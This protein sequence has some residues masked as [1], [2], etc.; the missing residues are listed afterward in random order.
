MTPRSHL[1]SDAQ[2]AVVYMA[3][4]SM[5]APSDADVALAGALSEFAHVVWVD[6]PTREGAVLERVTA[7]LSRLRC[8]R[9]PS[10]WPR[11]MRRR[12]FDKSI[13][14]ALTAVGARDVL[15]VLA[16]P[17]GRFPDSIDGH[18]LF[19]VTDDWVS[20]A[21]RLGL[22]RRAVH[23]AIEE[24]CARADSIASTSE[25]LAQRLH[26]YSKVVDA[27]R[28]VAPGCT[29]SPGS[30]D[31]PKE[32]DKS[33]VV[34]AGPLDDTWD[35]STLTAVA[36]AGYEIEVM[37][38]PDA[39]RDP[40]QRAA[41]DA[42]LAHPR[43]HH[44]AAG[45]TSASVG[46]SVGIAP[47]VDDAFTRARYPR[48]PLDYLAAGLAVVTTDSAFTR[49]SASVH[50][51]TAGSTAEFVARVSDA[52]AVPPDPATRRA[53]RVIAA[54]HSWTVRAVTMLRLASLYREAEMSEG[55]P[56]YLDATVH[57]QQIP[58]HSNP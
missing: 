20:G 34:V 37:T 9:T 22:N 40:R 44:D 21:P 5:D 25:V 12:Q 14:A 48:Q 4:K 50:V 41:L 13:A 1:A 3:G 23:S 2:P 46:A 55:A 31:A 16:D 6:P 47:Y 26:L 28:V 8:A 17:T 24:N 33:P 35:F 42:F 38:G 15:F 58:L 7:N 56:A 54:A 30:L 39:T 10:R 32:P 49:Q 53:R 11:P 18:R 19:D 57:T 43:A 52:C 29:F 45:S 36:D 27:V 51:V